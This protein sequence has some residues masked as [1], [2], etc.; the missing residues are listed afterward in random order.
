MI[1]MIHERDSKVKSLNPS[2]VDMAA[3]LNRAPSLTA[4]SFPFIVL[5]PAPIEAGGYSSKKLPV[6]EAVSF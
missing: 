3:I 5:L 1:I 4:L 6:Q 2:G